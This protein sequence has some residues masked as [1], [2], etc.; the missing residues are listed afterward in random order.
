MYAEKPAAIK[1]SGKLGSSESDSSIL[2]ASASEINEPYNPDLGF[3]GNQIAVYNQKFRMTV[4]GN[5][6]TKG[7]EPWFYIEV[8]PDI[9][10]VR[11]LFYD[12]DEYP[13]FVRGWVKFH[14][15]KLNP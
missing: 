7:E 2:R 6:E 4:I 10:P 15:I 9:K 5:K 13:T 3:S 11:S 14:D 1:L 8:I 12:T